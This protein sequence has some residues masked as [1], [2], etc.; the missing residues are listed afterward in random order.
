[1]LGGDPRICLGQKKTKLIYLLF[2]GLSSTT[3]SCLGQSI[4]VKLIR[5][6][7]LVAIFACKVYSLL[8]N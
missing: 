2:V 1:M 3:G 7:R 8:V 4:E 6:K 5:D